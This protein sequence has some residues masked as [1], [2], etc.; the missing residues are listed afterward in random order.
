MSFNAS[1]KSKGK[2]SFLMPPNRTKV[3]RATAPASKADLLEEAVPTTSI[4]S[5]FDAREKWSGL[6]GPVLNQGQCGSCYIFAPTEMLMDRLMISLKKPVFGSVPLSQQFVLNCFTDQGQD[7]GCG[8]GII[9]DLVDWIS[10]NPVPQGAPAYTGSQGSCTGKAAIPKWYGNGAYSVTQGGSA[11]E[12]KAAIQKEIMVNGPVAAAIIVYNDFQTWWTSS[13]ATSGVYKATNTSQSNVDG[14]HAIKVI[15]WGTQSNEPYWLIQNSWGLTGGIS[16]SGVYRL[17]D[18][19]GSSGSGLYTGVVAIHVDGDTASAQAQ[20][21][22]GK[23]PYPNPI[24]DFLYG[25]STLYWVLGG[26]A[27]L[28]LLMGIWYWSR[29]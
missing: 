24:D 6:I 17:Y 15:G 11:S 2:P 8:G 18:S 14:G 19:T 10:D 4:P 3:V 12:Q 5:T 7:P 22:A 13:A 9:Q 23:I 29:R 27:I 28:L 25:G 1:L 21:N 16:N 20:A 26:V